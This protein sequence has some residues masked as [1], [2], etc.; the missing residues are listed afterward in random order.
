VRIPGFAKPGYHGAKHHDTMAHI[1]NFERMIFMP[2]FNS[3][4]INNEIELCEVSDIECKKAV[5]KA[6]LN[7]RISYYIKWI[8]P[9]LFSRKKNICVFCVN[10]N[11][12]DEAEAVVRMICDETG[13]NV[14]FIM[15]KTQVDYL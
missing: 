15:K 2:S 14:R 1:H 10:D 11:V 4:K 7:K 3:Q 12:R 13:H 5:E 8:K 6:L 9:S